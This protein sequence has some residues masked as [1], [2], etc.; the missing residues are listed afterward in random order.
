MAYTSQWEFEVGIILLTAFLLFFTRKFNEKYFKRFSLA[1]AGVLIFEYFTHPL[2]INKNLQWWSFLYLDVNWIVTLCWVD[3]ILICLYSTEY[4]LEKLPERKRF[5]PLMGL[6][7]IAGLYLEW[8]FLRLNIRGYPVEV[9]TYLG[10]TY[11]ILNVVPVIE[12]IYI[13]IFMALIIGFIRYWEVIT[14]KKEVLKREKK[15]SIK[16][17]KKLRRKRK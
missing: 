9:Q 8:L 12:I 3:L 1:F 11:R 13:P 14:S 16:K 5:L 7:I 6:I 15:S 17:N 10:E 2:W 4:L